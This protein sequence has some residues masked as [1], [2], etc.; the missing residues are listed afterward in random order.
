ML[1]QK[2]THDML[3]PKAHRMYTCPEKHLEGHE[4]LL[5]TT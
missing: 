1:I 4:P 3:L 5:N 2:Y